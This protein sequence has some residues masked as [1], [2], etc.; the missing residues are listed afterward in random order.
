MNINR[1]SENSDTLCC[2]KGPENNKLSSQETY[3]SQNFIYETLKSP[4]EKK[5]SVSHLSLFV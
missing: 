4:F 5:L 3:H 1:E 2:S